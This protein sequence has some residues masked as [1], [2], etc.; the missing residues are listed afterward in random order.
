MYT[1]DFMALDLL[2]SFDNF[3][4]GQAISDISAA[5]ALVFLKYKMDQY[6]KNS[7][8]SPSDGAPAGFDAASVQISGPVMRVNVNVYITN[9]IAFVPITL[10]VSQVT[11]TA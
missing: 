9:A 4:V 7:L 11:Q 5:N 1:A 10:N 6:L 2:Q 3:A 8:I